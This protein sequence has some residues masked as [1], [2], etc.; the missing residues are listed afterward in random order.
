MNMFSR[1]SISKMF[2]VLL[3]VMFL[4]TEVH[5]AQA[6]LLASP[7][8]ASGTFL[9]AKSMGGTSSDFA[10]GIA[11]DSSG[12]VYTTGSF[13]GTADFDPGTGTADLTSAGSGD[14]FV[15]KL[16]SSGDF[17]WTKSMGGMDY[18]EGRSI[19]V[20]SSGSVYTTGYFQGTADFDPSVGTANLT[21]TG[22]DQIFVS[23]LDSSGDFVWAKSMGG[24]SD[25][26]G[27]SIALDLSGN[28][29]TTGGYYSTTADFDPDGA[30]TANL[31]NA[32]GYDIF[33]SKLE[34]RVYKL[35][36]PLILR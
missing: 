13:S 20:D 21:S 36:L 24:T 6:E 28:V 27:S 18:D 1:I 17:V 5:P 25:D 2:S 14:I 7:L 4:L 19:A 22:S 33:V 29:Y 12:N 32:G 26:G 15:S 8:Y 30:G 16:D 31:T 35:F 10:N 23:K 3:V 11:V 9:W 34:N